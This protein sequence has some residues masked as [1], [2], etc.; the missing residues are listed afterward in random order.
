[1]KKIFAT[2]LSL[3]ALVAGYEVNKAHVS[4]QRDDTSQFIV[5]ILRADGTLV[6]FAQ[7]GNGGWWNPWPKP[8]QP[9][10][11][12]YAES[13]EMIHHS[14]GDLPELQSRAL[15]TTPLLL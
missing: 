12:I 15:T 9:A 5:S 1:M 2:T 14:L 10:E 6:P 8:R 4:A 7:Y 11:S 13:T 3:L